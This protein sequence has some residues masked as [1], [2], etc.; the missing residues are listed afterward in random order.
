MLSKI[1]KNLQS[2]PL[3]I[4]VM[5]SVSIVSAIFTIALGW[6]VFY[7]DFLSKT[8]S[9]PV[10]LMLLSIII[11]PMLW[12]FFKP[13]KSKKPK[14]YEI[15]E[16]KKFGVQQVLLDGRTF[17]RC[18]FISSELVFNGEE[19]FNLESNKFESPVFTFGGAAS[20]TIGVLTNMYKDPAFKPLVDITLE[21]IKNDV[22]PQSTPIDSNA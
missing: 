1:S 20:Q 7:T 10:W 2:N 21:N 17:K 11:V 6:K 3:V 5:F 18:E 4:V 16:G 8:L 13:S 12:I 19:G 14:E 22:T 15:I 9:I